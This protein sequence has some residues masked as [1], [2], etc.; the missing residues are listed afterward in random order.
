MERNL[1]LV[2][3][4]ARTCNSGGPID[5]NIIAA[6]ISTEP[7]RIDNGV[8]IDGIEQSA[9]VCGETPSMSQADPLATNSGI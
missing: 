7:P 1:R 3:V 4:R 9:A 6:T 5:G 2:K 8:D